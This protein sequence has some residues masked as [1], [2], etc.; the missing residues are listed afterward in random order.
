MSNAYE[1]HCDSS[2]D[3]ALR[4]WHQVHTN[5]F[6][7]DLTRTPIMRTIDSNLFVRVGDMLARRSEAVRLRR[8]VKRLSAMPDHLLRDIGL[9]RGEIADIGRR[10]T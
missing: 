7:N 6:S 5:N 4:F 8:D 1:A 9:H 3:R 10:L 2:L